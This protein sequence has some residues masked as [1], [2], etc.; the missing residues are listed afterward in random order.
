M[1][2]IRG[3]Y[4][5]PV[6]L[7]DL[8]PAQKAAVTHGEGPLLIVAGAGTGKTQV[9][10]RRIAHIIQQNLAR[11]DQIV[12]LTFT[13]KAARE[14]E[15]RVDQ[16]LPYGVVETQIM[17]FH[18]FG[19]KLLRQYSLDIGLS[20][21]FQLLSKHQQIVFLKE[22]L[23]ELGLDYFAP[24]A[25]PTSHI[26]ALLSYFSR[27]RDELI[28]PTRYREYA[29][30]LGELAST[31]EE[32][33]AARK[34]SELAHAYGRYEELKRRKGF[35]DFGDQIALA[36]ELLE[37]RPNVLKEVRG[38]FKYL[39]VDEF[40]DTNFAQNR[41]VELVAGSSGNVCVVG[42]DDQSIY[43][44]RGAAISNI[45]NFKEQFK[46][47][48][49]IIL[50]QNYRSTQ[51]ILDSSYQLIQNNNPE[52]LE[53]KYGLDKYLIGRGAGPQPQVLAAA[54]YSLEAD[55]VATDVAARIKG[56]E[57][58]AE[59]AV[60]V[61]KKNQALG[62]MQ[63]L[64]AQ[65]VACRFT[66]EM[67]FYEE[68]EIMLML[69]FL[70]AVTDPGDSSALYHLLAGE[71]YRVDPS[72]LL[73]FAS[74]S[75][76]RNLPLGTVLEEEPA[77]ERLKSCL[78]QIIKWRQKSTDM[79]VGELCYDFVKSSGLID[80][81]VDESKKNPHSAQRLRNLSRF[82]N[83]LNDFEQISANKS[84]LTYTLNLNALLEAGE[85]P[86]SEASEPGEDEV[87]IMTVHRAKGL[88]FE[89]VYI[90]DLT[91]G[92]F[93]SNRR[94]EPLSIPEELLGAEVLPGGDWHI[95]EERRLMYVAMTR[96]KTNLIMTFSPDHGG[97]LM[98]KPSPFIREALGADP[99]LSEQLPLDTALQ[100]IELFGSGASRRVV[101]NPRFNSAGR[102]LLTPHQIDDYLT[103]PENF[104]YKHILEVPELPQPTLMY[105]NLIHTII[106]YYYTRKGAVSLEQLLG[107]IPSLW[108][109]EGFASPGQEARRRK[110]AEATV[111]GFYERSQ[112]EKTIP[113]YSEKSF[114]FELPEARVAVKGRMDAIFISP[115][116]KVEIR[117][118]K[119]SQVEEEGKAAK[120]A[121]TSVQL[122]IYALAW[123][124]LSGKLPDTVV[125]DYV[126]TGQRGAAVKT[127]SDM[128]KLIDQIAR[129]AAGIRLGHFSP[130]G[131]CRY[132][133]HR[134]VSVGS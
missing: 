77:S 89:T 8:N 41:L 19:E 97:K 113:A 15:E 112:V 25:S 80:K 51:E 85:G 17:T 53:A 75:R 91:K 32:K 130:S 131:N 36:V 66:D 47:A 55:L 123:K 33:L 95:Q 28:A 78:A 21:T 39:L 7:D 90:F 104:H 38:Q 73:A 10:T 101:S 110:M 43:K 49:Q 82:F 105:G 129:A 71:V 27:L 3:L 5:W 114:L 87:Q 52:R 24:V 102:L 45:L 118:F 56:G 58:P 48:K 134:K 12:G 29:D 94:A 72:E 79:T 124:Q 125:L 62:I 99:A 92:T 109:S 115:D 11:A 46:S 9:I 35:I 98:K 111:R 108:R 34:Q 37:R 18:S 63:S 81:L 16:L 88:E 93:P 30:S 69:D 127:E 83:G 70:R 31:D 14:M 44:F 133:S 40:Q 120:K 107:M 122:A 67:K 96:A 84:A 103:C 100:Q 59:I 126:D 26:E 4:N 42:D 2:Q 61:R 23:D 22:H 20:A 68:P 106:S 64:R 74:V 119:T 117:D 54:N 65:G 132:C 128:E 1:L 76:R 60:L 121:A 116:G 13:D 50:N 86:A 6:E 57:K